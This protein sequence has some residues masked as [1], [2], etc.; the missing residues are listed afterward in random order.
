MNTNR[1]LNI[2]LFSHRYWHIGLL[3]LTHRAQNWLLVKKIYG[4]MWYAI[5]TTKDWIWAIF[6]ILEIVIRL[7][8]NRKYL[9][10]DRWAFSLFF[11]PSFGTK[12]QVCSVLLTSK[13]DSLNSCSTVAL[14]FLYFFAQRKNELSVNDETCK[15]AH[16]QI[17]RFRLLW[18]CRSRRTAYFGC[19]PKRK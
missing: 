4:W 17:F 11:Y 19:L 1:H 10:F 9:N 18:F 5:A 14:F 6:V 3:V 2:F 15:R 16:T 7:S 13:I 8:I 12:V